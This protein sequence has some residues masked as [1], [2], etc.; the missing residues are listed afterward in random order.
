M[1]NVVTGKIGDLDVKVWLTG[2]IDLE[3]KEQATQINV[4]IQNPDG[5]SCHRSVPLVWDKPVVYNP[6]VQG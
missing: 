4:W 2:T 6:Y 1:E 3:T 5:T